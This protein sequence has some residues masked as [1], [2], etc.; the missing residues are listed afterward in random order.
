MTRCLVPSPRLAGVCYA[1]SQSQTLTVLPMAAYLA[2]HR[3]LPLFPGPCLQTVYTP[4]HLEWQGGTGCHIVPP[5]THH[6]RHLWCVA[7]H[8]INTPPDSRGAQEW[9][10]G[11]H[12]YLAPPAVRSQ[13]LSRRAAS[14]SS[15]RC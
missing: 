13:S 8:S 11:G 3:P 12:R 4:F 1:G 9:M 5:Q 7:L 15:W 6:T 2:V 14:L 10:H